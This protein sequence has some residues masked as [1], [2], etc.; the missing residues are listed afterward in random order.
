[1]LALKH[2][3]RL[4][5]T[6]VLRVANYTLQALQN[7]QKHATLRSENLKFVE[8]WKATP[9]NSQTFHKPGAEHL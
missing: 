1:L 5:Q 6:Q 4:V 9:L 8:T 7:T 2:W 3:L